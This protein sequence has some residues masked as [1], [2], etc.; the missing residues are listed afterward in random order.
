VY[1]RDGHLRV[2]RLPQVPGTAIAVIGM[3]RSGKTCF[4]WQ[5]LA[6]QLAA[7]A[8]RKSLL[9]YKACPEDH[10]RAGFFVWWDFTRRHCQGGV[11]GTEAV[12]FRVADV[13]AALE[14]MKIA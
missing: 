13:A 14:R 12:R 3:R 10:P 4:L 9:F 7:G 2:I 6:D 8:L 5:C 1:E 11:D